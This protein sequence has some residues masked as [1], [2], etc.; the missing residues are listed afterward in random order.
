MENLTK[1]FP[2]PGDTFFASEKNYVK[3][4]N[5]ITFE[6]VKGECLGIVGES[7]CGKST[8]GKLI[9]QLIKP[10]TGKI[11]LHDTDLSGLSKPELRKMRRHIQMVFQDPYASLDPRQTVRAA[12]E[13]PMAIHGCGSTSDRAE[14]VRQL[15]QEVGLEDYHA[16]RYPHEFSGGQRQRINVARALA[17]N[18]DV[19]ICDEPVSALDVSIQAQVVTIYLLPMI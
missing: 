4:V 10:T 7:G 8:T 1:F 9:L 15:L 19:I 5:G 11:F 13:E 12:L 2:I 18:P 3:A 17:L 16:D 6:V 14:R